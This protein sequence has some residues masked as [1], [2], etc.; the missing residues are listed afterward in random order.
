MLNPQG[1]YLY[2]ISRSSKLCVS[3]YR[4]SPGIFAEQALVVTTKASFECKH[5]GLGDK[6]SARYSFLQILLPLF[7]CKAESHQEE[8]L[9]VIVPSHRKKQPRV[10]IFSLAPQFPLH[11]FFQQHSTDFMAFSCYINKRLSDRAYGKAPDF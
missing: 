10:I 1:S 6:I 8:H 7:L 4:S 9:Q 11:F 5:E 2:L 3:S